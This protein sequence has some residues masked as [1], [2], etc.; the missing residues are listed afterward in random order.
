MAVPDTSPVSTPAPADR[1]SRLALAAAPATIVVLWT[2]FSIWRAMLG[3]ASL[4]SSAYDL[5]VYDLAI[6]GLPRGQAG[7][8]P[9]LGASVFSEHFRPILYALA[10]L[11]AAWPSVM[12]LVVLTPVAAGAAALVFH[13]LARQLGAGPLAALG[14][15]T[16]FLLARRTHGVF[17]GFFAPEALEVA[18]TFAMVWCGPRGWLGYAAAVTALLATSEQAAIFVAGF[19]LWMAAAAPAKWRRRG[20]LTAAVAAVWLAMALAVAI[21]ASERADARRTGAAGA[22]ATA[23]ARPLSALAAR[24]VSPRSGATIAELALTAGLLPLAAASTF[25]PAV[26]GLLL[27][28]AAPPGSL[29]SALVGRSAAG[30]L[31]W[32]FIAAA[33]GFVRIEQR[34]PRAAALWLSLLVAG[35]AADN[36]AL[37]R[38]GRLEH[39]RSAAMVTAQLAP[40]RGTVVLA[41]ANLIPHLPY[42]TRVYVAGAAPAPPTP[43]DLVLLTRVGNTWPL[44]AR[45]V[46]ALV[47]RYR[48]DPAYA[49]VASGPLFAFTR[50]ETPAVVP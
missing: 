27:H 21:P 19:G 42:D 33:A 11:H 32:L 12:L 50:R 24:V 49:E 6:H 47:D 46:N 2:A 20:L 37:Q 9:F 31:P 35:S 13:R 7:F 45:D 29:D 38:I 40:L 17:S 26:P 23:E 10:P 41:Q 25:A 16:A 30:V 5:S 1:R 22:G 28:L 4:D 36:P 3:H 18:L 34:W 39:D 44:S 43:P 8:V 48:H 15:M 14:L